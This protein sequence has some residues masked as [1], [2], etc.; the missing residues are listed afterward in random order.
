M[1]ELEKI[2]YAKSFIDKLAEG[3]N[4]LDDTP[5]PEGDIVNNVRLSRCFF[6]VSDILRQVIDNGGITPAKTVKQGKQEFSLT[7]EAKAKFAVSEQPRYISDIMDQLNALSDET[8]VKLP[9][10]AVTGWLTEQGFME[11]VTKQDGKNAKRPTEQG[12]AVGIVT[13]ERV[14]MYGPYTV[15]LYTA[16]AQ[17][18]ILDHLDAIIQYRKNEKEKRKAEKQSSDLSGFHNRPW[19]PEHD[20]RLSYLFHL[21]KTV[22]EMAYDLRRTEDGVQERL[23]TLGLWR[24]ES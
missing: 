5:V 3:T 16:E 15:V 11:I 13:E 22:P 6:Y 14:G 1:T 17:R 7:E 4:P 18:F 19:T 23:A 20:E 24:N 9:S 12:R 8:T 21:N 10:T 2:A